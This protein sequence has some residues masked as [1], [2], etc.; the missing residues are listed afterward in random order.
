MKLKLCFIFISFSF[1]FY[2]FHF[3]SVFLAFFVSVNENVIFSL[4]YIFVLVLI[5]GNHTANAVM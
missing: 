5:N 1:I 4:L 2:I 3:S